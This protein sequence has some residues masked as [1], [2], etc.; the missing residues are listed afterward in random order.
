MKIHETPIQLELF[1]EQQPST[2]KARPIFVNNMGEVMQAQTLYFYEK[3][4]KEGIWRSINTVRSYTCSIKQFSMFI[5]SIKVPLTDITMREL[6]AWR[7]KMINHEV[8]ESNLFQRINIRLSHVVNFIDWSI[9]HHYIQDQ[10]AS[11][12]GEDKL[13]FRGVKFNQTLKLNNRLKTSSIRTGP[14]GASRL[15]S[16]PEVQEFLSNLQSETRLIARCILETGMRINEV[17]S[18]PLK[19]LPAQRTWENDLARVYL[20]KLSTNIKGIKHNQNRQVYASGSLCQALHFYCQE[21]RL[22]RIRKLKGSYNDLFIS[23]KLKNWSSYA[24]SNQF[25]KALKQSN[26]AVK[27]TPNVLRKVFMTQILEN[28]KNRTESE[29]L[30]LTSLNNIPREFYIN[31]SQNALFSESGTLKDK[32][33]PVYSKPKTSSTEKEGDNNE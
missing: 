32:T 7:N 12:S 19:A 15:P 1:D 31:A 18:I 26:L 11:L 20:I 28:L 25:S 6:L 21:T 5:E 16:M 22:N 10:F 33:H 4:E 14:Q 8:R 27:I 13:S 2:I 24:I 30:I 3:I 9:K 29:N 17:L 23:P